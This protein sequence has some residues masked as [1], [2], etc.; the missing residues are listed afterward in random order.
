MWAVLATIGGHFLFGDMV[1]LGYQPALALQGLTPSDLGW[2]YAVFSLLSAIG[3]RIAK[4]AIPI[5]SA[6]LLLRTALSG[7]VLVGV[8]FLVL[9]GKWAIIAVMPA[10]VAFGLLIPV[11]NAYVVARTPSH[12]RATALSFVDLFW[13]FGSISSWLVGALILDRLGL[14]SLFLVGAI[15]GGIVIALSARARL[16]EKAAQ[17]SEAA[18]AQR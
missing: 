7:V 18:S 10:Q 14:R 6:G 12:L 5:V 1:W 15:G 8:G 16:G 4:W 9:P 2:L 17:P 11:A 3:T 13:N